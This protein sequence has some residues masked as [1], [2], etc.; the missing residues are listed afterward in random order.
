MSSRFTHVAAYDRISFFFKVEY[1]SI[2]WIYYVLL[3][4]SPINGYLDCSHVLAIVNNAA[5]NMGV[6]YIFKSPLFILLSILP[7]VELL[8]HIVILLLI[9]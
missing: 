5:I 6:E 3:I 1:C 2:V 7:E 4:H 9:L 8:D